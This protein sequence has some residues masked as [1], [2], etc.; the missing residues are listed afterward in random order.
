MVCIVCEGILT[1]RRKKY[2][3]SECQKLS[4]REAHLLKTYGITM[5]DWETIWEAQG[6]KCALCQREPRANETFHLDHEHRDGPSGPVRGIVCPF[7]NTRVIG[8]LKDHE[9]AQRLADYLRDP[10]A[11]KALGREVIAP[12]RPKKRRQPRKRKR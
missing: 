3:S 6:R 12:G 10:P 4:G 1:G 11:T 7:D 2:C 5:A 9:K 8:R